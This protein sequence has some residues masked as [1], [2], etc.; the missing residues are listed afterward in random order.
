MTPWGL[1]LGEDDE[2]AAAVG[3]VCVVLKL[4]AACVGIVNNYLQKGAITER[5]NLKSIH[6]FS[7]EVGRSHLT[8]RHVITQDSLSLK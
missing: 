8:V 2:V 5:P 7:P 1:W 6:P 3:Q 4:P